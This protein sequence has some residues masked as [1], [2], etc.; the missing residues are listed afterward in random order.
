[1]EYNDMY[2]FRSANHGTIWNKQP[3]HNDDIMLLLSTKFH[4]PPYY[5]YEYL[6]HSCCG[7]QA[8]ICESE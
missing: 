2:K 1:M 6:F 3:L 7:K 5:Y 4:I 8:N